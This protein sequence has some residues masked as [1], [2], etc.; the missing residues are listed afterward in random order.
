MIGRRQ[1]ERDLQSDIP[2]AVSRLIDEFLPSG[3]TRA[4]AF[5]LIAR[6]AS[7]E[8][9]GKDNEAQKKD[10]GEESRKAGVDEQ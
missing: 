8:C 9:T 7:G 5:R 10:P 6:A 2:N 1:N 4:G 3:P